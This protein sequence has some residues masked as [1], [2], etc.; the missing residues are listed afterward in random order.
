MAFVSVGQFLTHNYMQQLR[1]AIMKITL[2]KIP[3]LFV[4]Y[5]FLFEFNA[6]NGNPLVSLHFITQYDT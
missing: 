1:I 5:S 6:D 3:V 2:V 4:P